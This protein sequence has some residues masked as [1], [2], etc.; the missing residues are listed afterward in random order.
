[1]K[2]LKVAALATFTIASLGG[3]YG[4]SFWLSNRY[5]KD[6]NVYWESVWI[7]D[8]GKKRICKLLTKKQKEEKD[9]L[10]SQKL[11]NDKYSEECLTYWSKNVPKE[12]SKLNTELFIR[13]KDQKSI[14]DLVNGEILAGELSDDKKYPQFSNGLSVDV[15]KNHCHYNEKVRQ[16]GLIVI[17][18]PKEE[19]K[20][21]SEIRD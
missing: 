18:C 19:P 17:K 6:E 15:F 2:T 1:M 11:K 4:I 3:G 20:Q 16:N 13:A 5:E 10:I 8:G 12:S 9:K 7:L 21:L 14:E